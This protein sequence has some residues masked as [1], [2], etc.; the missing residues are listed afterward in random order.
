MPERVVP[1]ADRTA[2]QVRIGPT[3]PVVKQLPSEQWVPAV[4]DGAALGARAQELAAE[5]AR[6]VSR[7][8][9]VVVLRAGD[10]AR[11]AVVGAGGVERAWRVHSSTP[12]GEI[13]LAEPYADGVVMVV[14]S[15]TDDRSEF[16]VTRLGA[17]GLASSFSVA[18]ADW[19]E[20]APLS[21]FRLAGSSVYR[22]GSTPDGVAIDRFDLEV[23]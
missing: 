19:A 12:L 2:S 8:R 13:Q 14:R 11:I 9:N 21:R 20:T 1:L 10:E 17:R 6:P 5:S 16:T 22:L 7:T 23:R 15:Y 3:G 4:E 18:S